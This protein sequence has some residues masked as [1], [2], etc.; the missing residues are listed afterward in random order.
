MPLIRPAECCPGRS[1]RSRRRR[2]PSSPDGKARCSEIPRLTLTRP[3]QALLDHTATKVGIDQPMF[4]AP[5]CFAEFLIGDPFTAREADKWLG[6]EDA[7]PVLAP[8]TITLRTITP[9]LMVCNQI[10]STTKLAASTAEIANLRRTYARSFC[11]TKPIQAIYAAPQTW[12]ARPSWPP[13]SP[14]A[15]SG[16][17]RESFIWIVLT[18]EVRGDEDPDHRRSRR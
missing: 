10:R 5:D 11:E 3:S 16:T 6:H 15:R 4:G 9:R 14:A 8:P 13:G 17:P 2:T 18:A 1:W 7:H 12:S